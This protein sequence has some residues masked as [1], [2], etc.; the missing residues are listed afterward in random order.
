MP[1]TH[2]DTDS[3]EPARLPI[4]ASARGRL[5][6]L[7]MAFAVI[8][9]WAGLQLADIV[10]SLML[11]SE[12]NFPE[13]AL[14]TS[15]MLLAVPWMLGMAFARGHL[16][17]RPDAL[18]VHHR[19]VLRHPLVI[20][21]DQVRRVLIDDGS[22]TGRA[23]FPTGDPAE[24]LVWTDPVVRR[25]RPGRAIIG[26]D[27]LPD[28]AIELHEP[29]GLDAARGSLGAVSASAEIPPPP[30]GTRARWLLLAMEDLEAARTALVGY[31]VE[32]P[33]EGVVPPQVAEAA[34]R[35]PQDAAMLLTIATIGAGFLVLG[36][37]VLWG[38][39]MALGFVWVASMTRRRQAAARDARA[40]LERR[41]AG[42]SPED[43]AT[44]GAAVDANLRT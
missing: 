42:L 44:A 23:R 11:W 24:P 31:R 4:R 26:D 13:V 33:P 17:V 1:V 28:L 2:A 22:A 8:A 36:E 16:E 18:V 19:R 12:P 35:V 10:L 32:L 40:D 34:R 14:L 25:Q 37:P 3:M 41:A 5:L 7:G 38:G 39:W 15:P 20:P 27:L 30:R 9:L 43:R 6:R 29:I 21:R